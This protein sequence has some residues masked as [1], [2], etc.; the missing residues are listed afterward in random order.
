MR[1]RNVLLGLLV[2]LLLFS[3]A[4]VSVPGDQNFTGIVNFAGELW[5]D[6]TEVTATATEL[7]LMDGVSA[8]TANINQLSDN[9]LS[10]S[11][12]KTGYATLTNATDGNNVDV[13]DKNILFLDTST[14]NV[15]IGGFT[16]GV[17][18]QMLHIAMIETS[19]S[20]ALENNEADNDQKIY[21]SNG[22]DETEA[23]YGGW[24]LVCNG[25]AW[26]D[27]DRADDS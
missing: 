26:F 20:G 18:G 13:S 7:N 14:A 5:I 27:A 6:E 10:D 3:V 19:N 24:T 12:V 8:S 23:G 2:G 22:G 25:S 11:A 1:K 17:A 21:L 4:W 9:D 15:T 16:G